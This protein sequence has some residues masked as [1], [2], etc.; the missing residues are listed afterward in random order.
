MEFTELRRLDLS[1]MANN[2]EVRC[3]FLDRSVFNFSNSLLQ[4]D[5]FEETLKFGQVTL[6][7]ETGFLNACTVKRSAVMSP[8][9]QAKFPNIRSYEGTGMFNPLCQCR[10]DQK[11]NEKKQQ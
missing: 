11:N 1:S 7:S 5:L 8:E 6:P 3:P 2:I 4:T 10:I 9:L